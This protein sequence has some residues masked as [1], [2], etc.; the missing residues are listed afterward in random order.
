MIRRRFLDR[1]RR[2]VHYPEAGE[3]A[4]GT[5]LMMLHLLPGSSLQLVPLMQNLAP[6]HV[7]APDMAG[8]GDSDALDMA[9]PAITDLAADVVAL[10]DAR[11]GDRPVDLYGTHTGACIAAEIA[12]THPRKV[13][14]LVID[15]VPLFDAGE[16]AKL[17]EEYAPL[18]APDHEGTHFLKAHGFCRDQFLFYPWYEK[19]AAAARCGGLPDPATLFAFAMEVLKAIE[20]IPALYRA[21]FTYPTAERLREVPQATLC[22]AP[23]GDTLAEPTRQALDLLANGYLAEVP[24]DETDRSASAA[25]IAAFLGQD[26]A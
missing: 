17:A 22:L 16:A 15:G 2:Q 7:L 24:G 1:S 23:A 12:V 11:A 4:A 3:E 5:P 6:R 10:I 13:R 9:R 21:A 26:V 8:A 19:S 25:A 14:R 18:I 20:A